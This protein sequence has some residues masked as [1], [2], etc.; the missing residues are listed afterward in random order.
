VNKACIPAME[1][2]AAAA[3][4][5][6]DPRRRHLTTC[7]RCRALAREYHAFMA[8]PALPAAARGEWAAGVLARRLSRE[9]GT[10]GGV[11][12]PLHPRRSR[13]NLPSRALWATAAILLVCG[14]LFLA[15]DL[16]RE[17]NPRVPPGPAIVRGE[18]GTLPTL[19]VTLAPGTPGAW[20]LAWSLPAGADASV[21]VL[22]DAALREL[23][24]QDLGTELAF[25]VD[26]RAWPAA[27]YAGV[28]F[29]AGGDEVGRCAARAL[30]GD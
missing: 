5:Q 15:R 4:P 29:L 14:G 28:V 7:P 21:V 12:L 19:S 1:I 25:T 2:G 23:A 17:L 10:P 8:P 24:R 11:I 16:T 18:A 9:I 22:Y 6:D 30:V 27:A 20:R 26:A 3:A 13:L